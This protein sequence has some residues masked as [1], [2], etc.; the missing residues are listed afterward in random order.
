MTSRMSYGWFG[1]AGTIVS[2][3]SSARSGG[4]RAVP[5]RRVVQVVAGQERQQLADQ[6][7]A[8]AIVAPTAKCATPLFSLCVIAP[9]SSSLVTCSCVTVRMTSGPVTNM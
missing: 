9:P 7:E 1:D 2:S 3:A 4:S 6:E 5:P 8:L